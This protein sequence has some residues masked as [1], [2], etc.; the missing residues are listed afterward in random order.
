MVFKVDFINETRSSR[1]VAVE[2][3][4]DRQEGDGEEPHAGRDRRRDGEGHF[5][6]LQPNDTVVA[7][8]LTWGVLFGPSFIFGGRKSPAEPKEKE[9]MGE[10]LWS[11]QNLP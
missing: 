9:Q 2:S 10:R 4:L 11:S 3:Y 6:L 8:M 5:T 1:R 7:V